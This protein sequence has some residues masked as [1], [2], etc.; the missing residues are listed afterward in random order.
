MRKLNVIYLFLATIFCC[1]SSMG[2]RANTASYSFNQENIDVNSGQTMVY[3]MDVG[4]DPLPLMVTHTTPN[5]ELTFNTS[6]LQTNVTSLSARASITAD[7]DQLGT[8]EAWNKVEA[9]AEAQATLV[10]TITV[11]GA[12]GVPGGQLIFHWTLQGI[13]EISFAKKSMVDL[14]LVNDLSTS[15]TL[16]S[17]IPGSG[18][19]IVSEMHSHPEEGSFPFSSG[20][21]SFS[22]PWQGGSPVPIFFDLEVNTNLR[23]FNFD[24]RGFD[25]F[26]EVDAFNT[27]VLTGIA[28]FDSSGMALEN[29]TVISESGYAYPMVP[30][31]GS[32]LLLVVSLLVGLSLPTDYHV[33][34]Q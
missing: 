19:V 2:L 4:P 25:A 18:G 14:L 17:T 6:A 7:V 15:A 13:S 23:A 3:S 12:S 9:S 32:G 30:E 22:V 29:A 27:A 11:Q 31:P 24:A 8:N 21:L 28:V 34:R 1:T 33:R 20:A 16:Q 5:S 26:T 10:D